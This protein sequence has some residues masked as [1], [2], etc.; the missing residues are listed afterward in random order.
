MRI[1]KNIK[2][3]ESVEKRDMKMVKGLKGNMCEE[4]L[5][6]LGVLSTEQRS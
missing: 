2:L 4:W 5:Q 3:S 6:S 1:N